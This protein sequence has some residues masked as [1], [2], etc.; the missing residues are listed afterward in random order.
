VTT[1]STAPAPAAAALP[2][3]Q[4]DVRHPG[5]R[6]PN[7]A[8]VSLIGPGA[9][10]LAVQREGEALLI[11]P[12]G[13]MPARCTIRPVA[14]FDHGRFPGLCTVMGRLMLPPGATEPLRYVATTRDPQRRFR[15]LLLL[16][17]STPDDDLPN[18]PV[19]W[20]NA[21]R[22]AKRLLGAAGVAWGGLNEDDVQSLGTGEPW[23]QPV[24]ACVLHALTQSTAGRGRCVLEIGS[25]RGQSLALMARALRAAGR[26]AKIISVDPHLDQPLHR[27]YARLALAAIGE[28]RRL[29]QMTCRS[30]EAW[31]MLR[32]GT[33]SLIFIDGDHRR[34]QVLLDFRHYLDL[35]APGGCMVFHDYGYGPHNGRE[36]DV[37]G[38][39]PVVDEHVMTCEDVRPLLLGQT[40]M[41][42]VRRS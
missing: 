38:V 29:V 30:D 10:W 19:R 20:R 14:I 27:D 2:A 22:A 25:L 34:E 39:R 31:L 12:R 42:F 24:E 3:P 1:L 41:A 6:L 18:S 32:P 26:G 35:L 9:D 8:P 23:Y 11:R 17:E 4:S 28:E 33:A 15:E 5:N 40:M 16:V 36:D 21:E 37:P 7:D 13:P